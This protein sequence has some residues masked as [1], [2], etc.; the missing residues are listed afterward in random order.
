MAQDHT[1]TPLSAMLMP[2]VGLGSWQSSP[3]EIEKAVEWALDAGVKLID[4][5]FMYRNEKEIGGV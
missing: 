2:T 1:A 5:A 3:G 4:T